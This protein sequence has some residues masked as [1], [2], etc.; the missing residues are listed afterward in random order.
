[1]IDRRQ[2]LSVSAAALGLPSSVLAQT[3]WPTRLV[4]VVIP[5]AAGGVTDSVGRRLI[6]QMAQ[7]LGQPMVVENKGGA[8]GTVG[9]AEVLKAAPDG[10]TLLLASNHYDAAR[11]VA[12]VQSLIE[13]GV[14][15][16]VLVGETHH[17]GVLR[18]LESKR[19][20]FVNTWIYNP[21]SPAPCI[22]FDQRR[23]QLGDAM[24]AAVRC[25]CAFGLQRA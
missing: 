21:A 12:E 2:F 14:D 8:G 20:P 16:I 22:G 25:G 4:R 19:I 10:Y 7:A 24:A 23:F 13:H 9:M 17:P 6:D 11:E 18:L 15:A 5:Y 3:A 1:M